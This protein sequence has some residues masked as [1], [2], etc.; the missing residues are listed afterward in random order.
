MSWGFPS[1]ATRAK[2]PHTKNSRVEAIATRL[3]AIP[4]TVGSSCLAANIFD[5][6]ELVQSKILLK[7]MG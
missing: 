5:F 3:E 7:V 6:P 2:E 4:I 1:D